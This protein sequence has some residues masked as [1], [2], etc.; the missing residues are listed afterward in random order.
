M[1]LEDPPVPYAEISATL[2]ISVGSIGPVR[3]RCLTKLRRSPP[4]AAL[5]S[6]ETRIT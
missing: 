3:G 4:L 6:A 2:G 1:L 5:I